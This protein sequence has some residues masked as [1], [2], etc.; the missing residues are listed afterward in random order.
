MTRSEDAATA[1]DITILLAAL[2]LELPSATQSALLG[3]SETGQAQE[4]AWKAYDAWIRLAN[5]TANRLYRTPG[6]GYIATN[7]LEGFLRWQRMV[8]ALSCAFFETLWPALRLPTAVEVQRLRVDI[9]T[10]R[11]EL[12]TMLKIAPEA[13][14]SAMKKFLEPQENGL[15]K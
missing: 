5:E 10:L 6:V 1:E 14:A 15:Y 4:S 8:D 2:Y 11:D 7:L 3:L 13:E 12:R 9:R